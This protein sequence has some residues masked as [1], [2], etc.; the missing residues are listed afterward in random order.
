MDIMKGLAREE[1]ENSVRIRDS[2]K[3][4]PSKLPKGSLSRKIIKGN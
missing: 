4:A 1:V 3:K 2:Y